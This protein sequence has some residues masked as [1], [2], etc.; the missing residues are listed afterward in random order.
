MLKLFLREPLQ[1]N[2][3]FMANHVPLVQGEN[4]LTVTATDTQGRSF[5]QSVVVT[6]EI[7]DQYCTATVTPEAGILPYTGELRI[8]APTQLRLSQVLAYGWGNVTY[9]EG[10]PEL[11]PIDIDAPGFYRLE[12]T[13]TGLTT[14]ACLPT[15][16]R[17]WFT[18]AISWMPCCKVSGTP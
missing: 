8:A 13:A 16:W 9:G 4:T 10:P 5:S 3:E 17:C 11:F 12:V 6:A 2:G 1:Y 18:T 14:T 15:R 7:N